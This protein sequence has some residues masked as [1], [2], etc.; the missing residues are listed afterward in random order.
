MTLYVEAGVAVGVRAV[1]AAAS[2]RQASQ[3]GLAAGV[4][5]AGGAHRA[6]RDPGSIASSRDKDLQE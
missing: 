2:P 1:A 4:G 6:A 5:A 3:G